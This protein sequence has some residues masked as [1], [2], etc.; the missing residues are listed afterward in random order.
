[1]IFDYVYIDENGE[2]CYNME[3]DFIIAQDFEAELDEAI[4]DYLRRYAD[5][6]RSSDD[7]L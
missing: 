1:M 4:A 5:L 2:L 3:E 7:D 6:S